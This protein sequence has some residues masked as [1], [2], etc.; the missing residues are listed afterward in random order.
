[1]EGRIDG[2]RTLV[3][4]HPFRRDDW[5]ASDKGGGGWGGEE[6]DMMRDDCPGQCHKVV[7]SV[8]AGSNL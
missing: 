2:R 1:M 4:W 6:D 7:L 8:W 5:Y 3:Q